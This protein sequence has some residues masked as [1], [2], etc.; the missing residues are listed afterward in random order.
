MKSWNEVDDLKLSGGCETYCKVDL[1]C[2]TSIAYIDDGLFKC[3]ISNIPSHGPIT[4]HSTALI[5]INY[6]E[7]HM[8]NKSGYDEHKK[9]IQNIFGKIINT[10][11]I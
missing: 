6:G 9:F 5:S 11:H 2:I 8:K 10:D 4:Q 7:F 3:R 1:E